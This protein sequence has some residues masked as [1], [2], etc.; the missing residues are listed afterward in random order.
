MLASY[1]MVSCTENIAYRSFPERLAESRQN[2]ALK[3]V[4]L[5]KQRVLLLLQPNDISILTSETTKC[6]PVC[7]IITVIRSSFSLRA[8]KT[9]IFLCMFVMYLFCTYLFC[10]LVKAHYLTSIKWH[11]RDFPIQ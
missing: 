2:T 9:I 8:H 3:P 1:M 4:H 11:F 6:K 7:H 5:Q 10:L